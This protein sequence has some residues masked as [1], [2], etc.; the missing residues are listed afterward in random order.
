M[1]NRFNQGEILGNSLTMWR[2]VVD[3]IFA[4]LVLYEAYLKV[5]RTNFPIKKEKLPV[6]A[7]LYTYSESRSKIDEFP[8]R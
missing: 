7:F 1:D 4:N 2:F 3:V 8:S 5:Y 6:A